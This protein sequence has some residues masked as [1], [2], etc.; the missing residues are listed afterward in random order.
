MQKRPFIPYSIFLIAMSFVVYMP[1]HVLIV[2]SASLLTGGIEVWKAAKDVLLVTLVPLLLWV[3]YKNKVFTGAYRWHFLVGSAYVL[4]HSLFVLLDGSDDTRSAIIGS[5]YNSRLL[6]F[7]LLG[8]AVGSLK[9]GEKYLKWLLTATVLIATAVALFGVMQYFLPPDLLT[10]LGYSVDRGVKPLFF[11]DDKPDLPRVMSTLKDPNSLGAYLIVP[12]LFT[13]YALLSKKVNDRLFIRPFRQGTLAVMLGLQTA[14]L[15][16]TFSRGA[17]LGM[18]LS[19]VTILYIV[20]GQRILNVLKKNWRYMV[21]LIL[22]IISFSWL[23]W[24]SYIFQNYVFHADQ[25]TVLED[26]NE[27]RVTLTQQAVDAVLDKPIGH[28]PGTA[29]LVAIRNPQGGILTENYYLQIAYEVG[30]QGLAQ[31]TAILSIIGYKLYN[32]SRKSPLA[33]ILFASMIGY[34]FYS[35]LIHLWSNEA[36]SLQWWLMVGAVL[37]LKTNRQSIDNNVH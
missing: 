30:F 29:G 33:A 12:I 18:A 35:L 13:G 2:Q 5:V 7:M 15:F 1:L 28:G 14:A 36:V 34:L 20:T 27:L 32:M 19:I 16:L 25:S 37:G 9:E 10:H 3:A 31:F 24:D 17:L 23:S 21:V 4:L 22:L 6:G 8:L 11:I 26:P